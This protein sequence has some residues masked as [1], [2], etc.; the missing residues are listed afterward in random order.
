MIEISVALEKQVLQR[1]TFWVDKYY[2]RVHHHILLG[3]VGYNGNVEVHRIRG[4][5]KLC[6]RGSP[7]SISLHR[8]TF[9]YSTKSF[10]TT[11]LPNC[12]SL[13]GYQKLWCSL[14]ICLDFPS[15]PQNYWIR[16]IQYIDLSL[17]KRE[18]L[19]KTK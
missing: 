11:A 2:Y 8:T 18:S 12:P 17:I 3:K 4:G 15:S 16:A 13:Q 9:V 19:Y 10:L 5:R 7:K 14:L 1:W 6:I